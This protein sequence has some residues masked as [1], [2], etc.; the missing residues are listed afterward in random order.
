MSDAASPRH[1]V[2]IVGGGFG[3]MLAAQGLRKAHCEITVVDRR[4]FHLFQPLLYQVATGAL[5]PANIASPLRSVLRKQKNTRVLLGEVEGFDLPGKALLLKDGARIPFDTLILA[6]GATHTYFGHDEWA[7]FA[8]GLKTIEDATEIRRRVLSAFER[9][10]REPD[11]KVRAE[12]LTFVIVGGG[13]TGVE[14]AGSISELSRLTMRF[15]FRAIDPR[16]ARIV[17]IE[18]QTRVLSM[19]HEK[20]SAKAKEVLEKMGVEVRLDCHVTDIGP[21]H[22]VVKEDSGKAEAARIE[23][24]TI[25]WAAGVKASGLGKLL[26]GAIGGVETDRAGRVLIN[27]DC[28][29][30]SR[31]DVFV[32]GDLASLKDASGKPLP[33]QAPVAMQQG[34]YVA[35]LIAKRLKDDTTEPEPF[36]YRDKGSMATIGRAKAVAETGGLRLSGFIAWL[37]W[38]FIH[39]MYLARFENRV[40]VLW[41]WFFNYIT[42]GRAARLITGEMAHKPADPNRIVPAGESVV[43][44]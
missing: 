44:G 40:L 12:L 24:Q 28:T 19:F 1:K 10:E 22:V 4:N 41:Q 31:K 9:A 7:A 29:V 32:I 13:P 16:S 17:L 23:T 8:P 2:V 34:E 27:R 36:K 33:G 21:D 6:T 30:G 37:A 11:P 14:M 43:K 18:G 42:R 20:L 38:L 25:V 26:A 15:D 39:I 35:R 5:S 3:G